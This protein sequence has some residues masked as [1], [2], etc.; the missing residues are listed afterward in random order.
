MYKLQFYIYIC[1]FITWFENVVFRGV[2]PTS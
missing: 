1:W 2:L